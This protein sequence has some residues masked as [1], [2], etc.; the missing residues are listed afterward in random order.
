M[1]TGEQ[2]FSH[3]AWRVEAVTP[4]QASL[5][6][7]LICG[8]KCGL[9][10]LSPGTMD[11]KETY[12][13][14]PKQE[15]WEEKCKPYLCTLS[16]KLR[17]HAGSGNYTA[18]EKNWSHAG[19]NSKPPGKSRCKKALE[20]HSHHS[21]EQEIPKGKTSSPRDEHTV[22]GPSAWEERVPL[23]RTGSGGPEP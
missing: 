17:L 4:C 2:I 14:Q 15:Q 13:S 22:A 23:G 10:N 5:L 9:G 20:G 21:G 19:G 1:E 11:N 16:S 18:R 3:R 7:G 12:P 6:R 8:W